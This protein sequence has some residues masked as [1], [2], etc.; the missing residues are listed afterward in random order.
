[1]VNSHKIMKLPGVTLL[2]GV[3]LL[4]GLTLLLGVTLMVVIPGSSV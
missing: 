3:T 1:M 2:L 4:P